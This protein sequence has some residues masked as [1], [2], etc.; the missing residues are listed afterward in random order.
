MYP[1][2]Y[3]LCELLELALRVPE[4]GSVNFNILYYI[5]KTIITEQGLQGIK[6]TFS[7][8]SPLITLSSAG[9]AKIKEVSLRR[10]HSAESLDKI[11]ENELFKE[12]KGDC[13]AKKHFF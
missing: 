7:L 2:E 3:N 6:P 10:S 1:N 11:K 5:L 13:R 9:K 12:T 8:D 4:I